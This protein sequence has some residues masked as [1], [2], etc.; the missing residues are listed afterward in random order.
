MA[1][2]GYRLCCEK[3]ARL[4][5]PPSRQRKD[6]ILCY[7]QPAYSPQYRAVT[8]SMNVSR[9]RSEPPAEKEYGRWRLAPASPLTTH[10]FLIGI[11]AIRNRRKFMKAK[12]RSRF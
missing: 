10:G 4:R 12:E 3:R 2:S 11:P 6:F 8:N 1:P 5:W 7:L 9:G